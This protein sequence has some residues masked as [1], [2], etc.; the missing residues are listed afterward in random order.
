MRQR[1][2]G[3]PFR[4]LATASAVLCLGVTA[5]HAFAGDCNEACPADLNFDG[6][7]NGADL[8]L[9]L[10]EWELRGCADFDGTGKVDGADLGILLAAWG[11]CRSA[12]CGAPDTGDCCSKH[13]T[14]FCDN[15]ACC[16]LVCE[17]DKFCCE[18]HWDGFCVEE[19][20]KFCDICPLECGSPGSGDCC[21]E[22]ET[23]T[24]SDTS[25]CNLVC[26]IDPFCCESEWDSQCVSE[27]QDFCNVC[28]P[29]CG[30]PEAG[31]CCA[32]HDTPGCNDKACCFAVCDTLPACCDTAWDDLCVKQALADCEGC[33]AE[34][35]SAF[36]PDCCGGPAV[37][38]G[39]QPSCNEAACC[40]MVCSFDPFCCDITW[41]ALC[42]QEA[43]VVCPSCGGTPY[44]CG[45]PLAGSCFTEHANPFCG[46]VNC[47]EQVCDTTP[48]CCEIGWDAACVSMAFD[49]CAPASCGGKND[50]DCCTEGVTPGCED[51]T[52]C[53]LVCDRSPAC[54]DFGWDAFCAADAQ[55]L[56]AVCQP[57]CPESDH[58]CYSLGGPGCTDIECCD[59]VCAGRG[60]FCCEVQWD[61]SCVAAALQLCGN[62]FMCGDP[63]LG[64]CFRPTL[65]PACSDMECCTTVCDSEPSCCE[66]SWDE[67]CVMLAKKLCVPPSDCC[68]AHVGAGCDDKACA[69]LVCFFDDLC[70]TMAWDEFCATKATETCTICGGDPD[71]CGSPATG[72]CFTV[73]KSPA[74]SDGEC[75]ASVCEQDA[76]CC[77][78]AWDQACVDAAKK[79]CVTS[80]PASDHGCFVEG[81][82]GCTNATCCVAV[83]DL[84]LECCKTA[85]DASC[86]SLAFMVCD[87]CGDPDLGDCC[88]AGK[89]AFCNDAAC[90]SAV[91]DMLPDCC[92]TQWDEACAEAALTLCMV[93]RD[94]CGSGFAGD[95]CAPHGSPYCDQLAC[96]E[97]VCSVDSF[98]CNTVWDSACAAQAQAFEETCTC[99]PVVNNTCETALPI[100]NGVTPFSNVNATTTGLPAAGCDFFGN[101][102]VYNDIWFD[103]VATCTGQLTI[104]LCDSTFDTKLAVYAGLSC[105]A[106]SANLL[107]CNDDACGLRSSITIP[108][109]AGAMLK[110][111]VGSFSPAVS[112]TGNVS[113]TCE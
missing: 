65:L 12:G 83:C 24:C 86:V 48:E 87:G 106:T 58:D 69:E 6:E 4:A 31:D 27:A 59:L 76:S 112:G 96:C 77:E 39:N 95:C 67:A 23:P 26:K 89:T 70:C 55:E 47:C 18:N 36:A 72:D 20:Q 38:G 78:T 63:S 35:G 68:L 97:L 90:C 53:A 40:E 71:F 62:P 33:A 25:C 45:S 91:C 34:C 30:L 80:C 110:I 111:R 82:V 109:N 100:E 1:L 2:F 28:L 66:I 13:E 79:L 107:A 56:C 9:L 10:A 3:R 21:A 44:F 85:W 60:A 37:A 15:V 49:L 46:S 50:N 74:C 14:P 22:H 43:N 29:P 104:S 94:Q 11:P 93:C 61:E 8:G 92:S 42:V 103:Y 16:E 17:L 5:P 7:V 101:D 54:C 102:Q 73:T 41:N 52:C 99:K 98:C 32:V 64:D 81:G 113:I 19:A 88:T 108:V 51:I 75:C 57:P 105:P 84:D